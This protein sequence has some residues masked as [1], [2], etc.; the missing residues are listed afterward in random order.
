MSMRF[1]LIAI[2]HQDIEKLSVGE[3]IEELLDEHFEAQND[4]ALDLD[5][6]WDG[7]DFLF[8]Q[9]NH[10]SFPRNWLTESGGQI[11]ED[12][13]YGPARVWSSEVVTLIAEKTELCEADSLN[14]AFDFKLFEQADVYPNIWDRQ[15]PQDKDIV[16]SACF[17]LQRMLRATANRGDALLT[18]LV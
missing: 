15:D 5:K 10:L 14:V 2:N 13:G 9:A 17:H 18:A 8:H 6:N 3:T 12:L 11:D 16:L 4:Y 7:V 1:Q